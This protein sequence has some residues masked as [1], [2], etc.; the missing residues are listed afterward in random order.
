[1]QKT[2]QKKTLNL[3]LQG[4]GAHGALAWGILDKLLEDGRVQFDS[5]SATS[6]G[7]MNAAVL[8]HGLAVGGSDGARE[9]LA[10][11]WKKMVAAGE[12]YNP[13]R[14]SPLEQMLN[15]NLEQSPSYLFFQWMTQVF[16]PYQFNP[17][18]FNPLRDVLE[19][20]ID[21]ERI[22]S[23]EALRL[24]LSATNVQTGKIKIF[25]HDELSINAILASA[26]LPYLFQ[27]IE[28]DGAFYWDGGYMGNPAIFPL[29]Y[30]AQ[31]RDI[32]IMHINPIYREALPTTV[33]AISN[34]INEISFNSSF[35][36]EMRA[37]AFVSKLLDEN[38]IKTEFKGKLKRLYLHA[39]R[40]DKVMAEYS[41]ATK[42]ATDWD[43]IYKL[44]QVGRGEAEVWLSQHFADLGKR[45]T[46]DLDEFM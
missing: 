17:M 10:N 16:S 42:L 35:M 26:C 22:K 43:F 3:A 5:V 4:G 38:W 21:I 12:R 25:K 15:T 8:A 24:F 29:I 2:R 37:I 7:A 20:S 9:A 33:D 13:I 23:S 11:F 14:K 27:A 36:R 28:I 1:M 32:L 45:T 34:R 18:N 31:C 40:A 30:H 44:F 39:I 41:V 19:E 6:A 46:I